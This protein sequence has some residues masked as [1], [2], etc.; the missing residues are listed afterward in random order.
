MKNQL[1]I[2][3]FCFAVSLAFGGSAF[4]VP[5]EAGDIKHGDDLV[6]AC[7][8]LVERDVSDDGKL[9]SKACSDF[10]GTMVKKVYEATEPGMPTQFSRVGPKED[11]TVCFR[12]PSKLSFVDFAKLILTYR[13]SHPELDE[14]PAFELGAWTLSVNFPCAS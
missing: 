7:T 9:A 1:R 13:K 10:L 6:A 8:A 11:K 12:L 2:A 4:A 3:A 14:R 5:A